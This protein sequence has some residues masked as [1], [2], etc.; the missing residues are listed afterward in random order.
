[1]REKEGK[2]DA[3]WR[4]AQGSETRGE[5]EVSSAFRTAHGFHL[6]KL[7]D[8]KLGDITPPEKAEKKI[9]KRLKMMKVGSAT[10]EYVGV[11]KQKA[12]IKMYF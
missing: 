7:T 5:G 1:M 4:R 6:L 2:N 8:R 3:E 12:T 9:T 10:R 11:L